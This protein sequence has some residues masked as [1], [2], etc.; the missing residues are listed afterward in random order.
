M[1]GLVTR[2][3]VFI[4]PGR[5][6]TRTGGYEY[7]RRIVSGLRALGWRVE[8]LELAGS[9]PRPSAA[10]LERAAH[11]LA[12]I[13]DGSLV[14]V[15]GLALSAMPDQADAEAERLRLVA[16]VHMPLAAEVGLDA[17]TVGRF[18]ASERRAL[19]AVAR[20][21]V[22]GRATIAAMRRHGLP[23]DSIA[24]V[25]PGTERAPLARGSRGDA[26]LP[27]ELL[28]VATISVGKGHDVLFRALAS[29][30]TPRWRLT[31][32]G[33]LDRDRETVERLGATAAALGIAGRVS[34]VG[35]Q[36]GEALEAS[37]DRADVFVLATLGETYGMAVAEALAHGLPVVS[38]ATGAIAELVGSDAGI[39]VPPGDAG[40]LAD[41]LSRVVGDRRER[42]RLTAGARRVRDGLPT[43]EAASGRMAT[44][45]ETVA[46]RG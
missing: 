44:V 19:A 5:L 12:A 32:V 28:S 13:A 8:V 42:E 21:V 20:V 34:L 27:V 37:W 31:C 30:G 6:E 7:D 46:T 29:M 39:V 45:L 24:L 26:G 17:E 10:D 40:A 18:D 43:W 23:V 11:A 25:E 33:S 38:T 36:H 9:F 22:T 35:E 2:R 3:L 15:D 4:V 16:L 41:A 1:A 14:V